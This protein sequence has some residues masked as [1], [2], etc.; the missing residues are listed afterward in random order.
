MLGRLIDPAAGQVIRRAE[1][2]GPGWWSGAPG[3]FRDDRDG[4]FWLCYRLRRPRGRAPDRGAVARI[5]RSADGL[6]FDDVLTVT[7]DQFQSPSIE[8]CALHRDDR[9]RWHYFVSY[10]DGRTGRWR[11]DRLE[12]DAVERLEPA[13]RQT[14]FTAEGLGLEGV[15]DPWIARVDR[16]YVMLLSA[17][18]PVATTR[19]ESHASADIY[20]TGDCLSVSCLATS[21][22]LVV[23]SY[24]GI[25]FE[26]AAGQWDGYCARLTGAV[27]VGQSWWG[28]YDGAAGVAENY[29][30]RCGLAMSGDLRQWKRVSVAGPALVSPHGSGSLRYVAP[31]VAETALFAYYEFACEDGSHDLRVLMRDGLP[32]PLC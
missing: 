10:V 26:P 8:R 12:A 23:W 19:P 28:L 15:K 5:A 9:G 3:A 13:A 4:A 20:N 18:K 6:H 31:I 32:V 17:A 2:I 27:R 21:A 7:K 14:V 25:V 16:G 30:E 29:E 11:I 24:E 22:D 1:G